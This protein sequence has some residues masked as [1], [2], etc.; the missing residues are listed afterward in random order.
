MFET[1]I[2]ATH[3]NM[4]FVRFLFDARS[5]DF[6]TLRCM[7]WVWTCIKMQ[8]PYVDQSLVSAARRL[9]DK[10]DP[11]MSSPDY[12]TLMQQNHEL[13][14]ARNQ[15][16]EMLCATDSIVYRC[17]EIEQQIFFEFVSDT[18]EPLLGIRAEQLIADA[19]MVFQLI[20]PRD[21][22]GIRQSLVELPK[23][24]HSSVD[25]RIVHQNGE[26]VWRRDTLRCVSVSP[27]R[28]VGKSHGADELRR[29]VQKLEDARIAAETANSAK[30]A[31]L[32]V[33]SH[34]LRTPLNAVVGMAELALEEQNPSKLRHQISRAHANAQLLLRML[35]E[36]L[37]LA[38]IDAGQVEIANI[39]FD[40]VAVVREECERFEQ[41]V[42]SGRVTLSVLADSSLP[43]MVRGDPTRLRQIVSNLVDNAVKFTRSGSIRLEIRANFAAKIL[44]IEVHDTGPGI[45]PDRV[46]T[47]FDR[48]ENRASN[49][50][51]GMTKGGQGLIIANYFVG[52][53]G[54]RIRLTSTVGKGSI[55][56]VELPL[57]VVSPEAPSQRE[58]VFPANQNSLHDMGVDENR[59]RV[60][61]AEDGPDNQM[62]ARTALDRAGFGVDVAENGRVAAELA[63]RYSYDLILMDID[64]PEVD[65]VEAT[66]RIRTMEAE[67]QRPAV[68]I[69]A[70]TAHA[71]AEYRDRCIAAGMED[72]LTKPVQPRRL[73]EVAA[74]R[75][76][77]RPWVLIADDFEDN[78]RLYQMWIEKAGGLRVALAKDGAEAI[79]WFDRARIAVAILD[80]EMPQKNGMQVARFVREKQGGET[81]FLVCLTGHDDAE[82][83]ARAR[84]AGF[85]RVL[86][87]PVTRATFLATIEEGLVQ[88][89]RESRPGPRMRVQISVDPELM[90]LMPG[91]LERRL[92]DVSAVDA[93]LRKGEFQPIRRLGDTLHALG[94]TYGVPAISEQG[95]R[96]EAAAALGDREGVAR[97]NGKIREL[98]HHVAAI[99]SLSQN[100]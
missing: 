59:P 10:P 46:K 75:A 35:S 85:D 74:G 56:F 68:P 20:D 81:P 2:I 87:K 93:H 28:F 18:V 64:M 62:V 53:M 51:H 52:L 4:S 89:V 91:F 23:L 100:G 71:L 3:R 98:L 45:A 79:E 94:G 15:L 69:V 40:V 22:A 31:F 43:P 90:D 66:R 49:T 38:K 33:V 86:T 72:F 30:S 8:A 80:V 9:M 6:V 29:A 27:F 14:F 95:S 48:M 67:Q 60:L 37:D 78:R 39:P 47:I 65:G 25:Y 16:H 84:E 92:A 97:A 36:L 99:T 63:E 83:A 32:A 58:S 1:G 34:E 17:V 77:T 82:V 61:V 57:V 5:S 12:Q 76:D 44:E 19:R 55:F 7:T 26:S 50:L 11:T 54:G 13:V 21:V 88:G 70:L 41:R 24:G 96:L 42:K 73:R